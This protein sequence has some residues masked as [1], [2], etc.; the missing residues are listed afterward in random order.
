[1]ADAMNA[2][3]II[4]R[5]QLIVDLLLFCI[6]NVSLIVI[7]ISLFYNML[8]HGKFYQLIVDSIEVG[9]GTTS[10]TLVDVEGIPRPPDPKPEPEPE[11]E[12]EPDS[13]SEE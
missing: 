1:G 11:P 4:A 10:V 12:P 3:D 6:F 13:N 7:L 5:L 9:F 8:F 2:L